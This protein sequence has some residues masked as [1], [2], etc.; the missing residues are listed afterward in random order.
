MTG[1]SPLPV[2]FTSTLGE[3]DQELAAALHELVTAAVPQAQVSVASGLVSYEVVH[4]QPLAALARRKDGFRV[5]LPPIYQDPELL[6]DHRA[7]LKPLLVGKSCLRVR[8]R[9]EVPD[10]AVQDVLRRGA[11]A[12]PPEAKVAR[13]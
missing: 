9:E 7:E 6:A 13:T 3:E 2:E 1:S 8:R 5:Y 12:V 4:G 10:A 11:A